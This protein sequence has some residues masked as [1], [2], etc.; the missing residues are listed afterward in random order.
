MTGRLG[1]FQ[2]GNVAG[3]EGV[4]TTGAASASSS[5]DKKIR[6]Q[7]ARKSGVRELP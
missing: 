3:P 1:T 6:R 7:P 4:R 2:D 5:A